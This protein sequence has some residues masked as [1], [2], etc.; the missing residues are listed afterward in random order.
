MWR[1]NSGVDFFRVVDFRGILDKA[2]YKT[3]ISYRCVLLHC[4]VGVKPGQWTQT[5]QLQNSLSLIIL[6][7]PFSF[8]LCL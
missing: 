2:L 8:S 6:F 1:F 5:W 7:L 4:L 3:E